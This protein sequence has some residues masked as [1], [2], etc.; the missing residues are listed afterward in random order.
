[1]LLSAKRAHVKLFSTPKEPPAALSVAWECTGCF[2]LCGR[3]GHVAANCPCPKTACL[4]CG[5][6]HPTHLCKEGKAVHL[7][8]KEIVVLLC[9]A[10]DALT[11]SRS[12]LA[13]KL[14]IELSSCGKAKRR[15][16]VMD[17]VAQNF[18]VTVLPLLQKVNET[19][20]PK[21]PQKRKQRKAA[22]V[23]HWS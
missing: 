8:K 17:L 9:Q 23:S 20:K 21:R 3:F 10:Y 13:Q 16:A 22:S 6:A 2:G 5:R 15:E 1:M 7:G 12:L 18:E 11:N 19:Q 4:R 14:L